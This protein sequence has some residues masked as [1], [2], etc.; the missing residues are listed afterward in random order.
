MLPGEGRSGT[1]SNGR[2]KRVQRALVLSGGGGLGAY[3]VGACQV[4]YAQEPEWRP[5]LV[6]GNSI[7]AT[8][9]AMLIAP[10]TQASGIEEL[11]YAWQQR[12]RNSTMNKLKN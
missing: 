5:D 9:G 3:Q 7:G 1:V 6:I 8:N 2:E 11:Q 4:L 12:I 10:K